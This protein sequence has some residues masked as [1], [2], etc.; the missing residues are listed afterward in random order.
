MVWGNNR[1]KKGVF[2]N[3]C[4]LIFK[5]FLYKRNN[6]WFYMLFLKYC[7]LLWDVVENFF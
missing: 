2:I 4:S 6:F 3:C 7:C 5:K 1:V